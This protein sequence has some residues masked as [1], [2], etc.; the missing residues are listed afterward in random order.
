MLRPVR[1]FCRLLEDRTAPAVFTVT[2]AADNGNNTNPVP[3]SFRAALLAANATPAI[4][5][6][7]FNIP[8][9]GAHVLAPVNGLPYIT[10]PVRINGYSQ[11][12]ASRNTLAVGD[13]ATILIEIRDSLSAAFGDASGSVFEGLAVVGEVRLGAPGVVN[14]VTIRGNFLGFHADGTYAGGG[15]IYTSYDPSGDNNLA[16]NLHIGGPT[17]AD[18]NVI[19]NDGTTTM[20]LDGISTGLLVQS[21]YFGFNPDGVTAAAG[22]CT[23]NRIY[24]GTGAQVLD[25]VIRGGG[26]N[27]MIIYGEGCIVRGNKFG[28]NATGTAAFTYLYPPIYVGSGGDNA[29]IGGPAPGDANVIVNS[30]TDGIYIEEVVSGVTISRNVIHS[31]AG[32]GIELVGSANHGLPSPTV[33]GASLS[34]G[35]LAV[36]GTLAA[37]AN[38]TFTVE[39]FANPTGGDEGQVFLGTASVTTDAA[40]KGSFAATVTAPPAGFDAITATATNQATGDTSEFSAVKTAGG[41]IPPPGGKTNVVLVGYPQFAV[42]ADAGSGVVRFFNPDGSERFAVTPFPGLA[43][44]VRTAAADFNADG[45]ADV[46]VGTG[47]GSPTRVRVLD[48]KDQHE[49]FAVDPFEASFKGGVFVAAGDVT[50]DGVADFVVTPDE[51]GGPR[52]RVFS[53]AGF[54]LVADFFGIDDTA[55]RGGARAAVGDLDGDGAADLVV[56]AGFGGGPRLA[57]FSGRSLAGVPV[58]LFADFLAFEPALRNGTFVAVG[59]TDGDGKAELIAGGGPGGGP[60]V[61]VF[62]GADLPANVQTRIADFFAGDVTNRGGVRVAVKDLDGDARADLVAGAGTGAG[63]RVTAYAGKDLAGGS[64][65]ELFALDAFAGFAGGVFVG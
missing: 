35:G 38:T 7:E 3:G 15:E 13:D 11:P 12:G 54:G 4:D 20:Y 58:K 9:S 19:A 41:V 53:G 46:V 60:R 56:A 5:D 17:P 32:R 64:P 40:G 28:T 10:A 50:G 37:T 22:D 62:R 8:G 59:D 14:G 16:A 33:T 48:G 23:E 25:N 47:P 2:T 29:V 42:G 44:G 24:S 61:S 45:V 31:N 1:L 6:I 63:S 57:A 65:P 18:R 52:A 21:N 36:S 26:G 27:A 49:L 43:G 34:A 51:G 55:F 39:V 30:G